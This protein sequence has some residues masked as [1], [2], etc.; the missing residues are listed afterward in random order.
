M[1]ASATM[2]INARLEGGRGQEPTHFVYEGVAGMS[3]EQQ[4]RYAAIVGNGLAKVTVGSDFS[5]KDYG[6]GG[7]VMVSVTLTCD[8]S[9]A[10]TNSAIVLAH[11]ISSRYAWHYRVLLKQQLV[12]AG[13]LKP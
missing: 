7:G 11:E 3:Q 9:E 8:Q 12:Q 5:E 1:T 4:D 10:M 6:N 2:K 13:V